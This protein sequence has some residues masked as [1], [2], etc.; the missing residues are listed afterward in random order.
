MQAFF[1]SMPGIVLTVLIA[2]VALLVGVGYFHAKEKKRN[3]VKVL[4]FSAVAIAL[5]TALSMVIS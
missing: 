5:G 4:V 1:E 3:S 2:F